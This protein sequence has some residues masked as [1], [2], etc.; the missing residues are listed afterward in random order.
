MGGAKPQP[1]DNRQE[2]E[3]MNAAEVIRQI[4][5]LPKEEQGQVIDFVQILASE[6]YEAEQVQIAIERVDAH[7]ATVEALV[8]HA[9]VMQMLRRA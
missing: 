3:I 2:F 6:L 1:R 9:D 8:S 4:N 5:A 7:A